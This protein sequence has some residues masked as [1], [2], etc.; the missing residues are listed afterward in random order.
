MS[1]VK[2]DHPGGCGCGSEKE[3]VP[4]AQAAAGCC[5][6][7][8][9]AAPPDHAAQGVHR[10][11]R[12]DG[13]KTIDP[14]CGMS[15]D[16]TTAKHTFDHGGERH[17]FC[18]EGCRAKFAAAPASYLADA[19]TA[20]G[21]GCCGGAAHAD[22]VHH[23]H[24]GRAEG[25]ASDRRPATG[26]L[27]VDPVCGM[28]VDPGVSEHKLQQAGKTYH[29]CSAGCR[30]KFAA[31]PERYLNKSHADAKLAPSRQ[32][33]STPAPCIRRSAR[34]GREAARSAE[35]RSNPN[36]S[37]WTTGRTPNSPT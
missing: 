8:S 29:F 22:H 16:P 35:W 10:A 9:A 14:V 20:R 6:G 34:S 1:N 4:V 28:S 33:R 15:V 3:T 7:G 27:A 12:P 36:W 26:G 17:H 24:E 21:G 31:D 11:E 30:T 19:A 23:A 13:G 32:A 37:A 18:S 25:Q 2:R 5:G